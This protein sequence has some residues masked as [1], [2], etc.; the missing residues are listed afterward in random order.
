[1]PYSDWS[2]V[3][4]GKNAENETRLYSKVTVSSCA[5]EIHII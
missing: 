5:N 1:M 3:D 2:T 4:I